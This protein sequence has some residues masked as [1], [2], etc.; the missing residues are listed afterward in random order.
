MI[1]YIYIYKQKVRT[2]IALHYILIKIINF[3]D[4]VIQHYE[5]FKIIASPL[6]HFRNDYLIYSFESKEDTCNKNDTGL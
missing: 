4:N 1:K 6:P 3:F 5:P 2:Y